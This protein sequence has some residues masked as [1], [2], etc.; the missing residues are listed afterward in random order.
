MWCEKSFSSLLYMKKEI[1]NYFNFL[2]TKHYANHS[3]NGICLTP[4]FGPTPAYLT[5]LS[6]L[7]RLSPPSIVPLP[8]L[9]LLWSA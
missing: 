4:T 2:V 1:Y 9:I 7:A 6:R 3:E 5:Y 8:S